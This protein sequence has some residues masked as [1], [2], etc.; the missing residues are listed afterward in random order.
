MYNF[1]TGPLAWLSFTMFFLG[2]TARIIL[3]IRGLDWKLDRVTYTKNVTYGIR[4]ASRSIF[5]WL[6]PFGTRS[7]RKNS[8]FTLTV[9]LFHIGLIFTPIFLKA[10]NV[11]LNERWGISFWTIPDPVA[12]LLTILVMVCVV[13]LILRRI[14]LPEVRI[15]TTPYDFLLLLISAAPFITG[16]LA[17]HQASGYQFWLITHILCGEI[18]LVAI[19][20]TKLS[21]F[22]LFF[23]SRA[24]LG[25]DFGI[26]RGG[27]KGR[28]FSW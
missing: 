2:L 16:Y 7:W 26:K 17:F 18:M 25:M 22:F 14:S 5:F 15:I 23:L 13:L 21:H 12:D 27:M 10:H 9:F 6:L 3:Y 20:F 8:G 24:Q 4:G 11:I 19:P 1:V 28:G